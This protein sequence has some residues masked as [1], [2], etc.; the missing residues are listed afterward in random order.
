MIAQVDV[1]AELG[2]DDPLLA[3]AQQLEQVALQDEYFI[4]R[5]L[6]PNVDFYSGRRA[7]DHSHNW[8]C[9]MCCASHAFKRMG[10]DAT[11]V[12]P[13]PTSSRFADSLPCRYNAAGIGHPDLHV[14]CDVRDVAHCWLGLSVERDGGKGSALTECVITVVN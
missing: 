10:L 3:V 7:F 8:V 12:M 14:Y 2:V 5:K 11:H 6:Y 9:C 4:Q 1:L 13:L